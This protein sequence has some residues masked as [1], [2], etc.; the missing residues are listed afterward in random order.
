MKTKTILILILIVG[1]TSG[2]AKI[3][4]SADSTALAQN[5]QAIAIAPPTV[6]IAATRKMDG[7]ALIEQ[8]KTESINFQKETYSWMLKRKMQRKINVEIQD[9]ETTIA[10]LKKAGYYD[11]T[12]LSPIEICEILGVD[13]LITSNY[14]LSKPMSEGAAVALGILVGVW[15]PTNEATVAISIHDL[16]TKKMIW[17]FNHKLSGSAFSSP[18]QIVDALMRKASRKMPYVI[19]I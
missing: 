17:N 4:Y 7:Q 8:Q 14:S 1:I 6:S 9:I 12:P 15:G 19:Q 5:H 2:C 16:K 18:A 10:K 13:G 11:G 3:Y